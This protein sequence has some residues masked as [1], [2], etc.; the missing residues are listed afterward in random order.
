MDNT[1]K[2]IETA[3][4]LSLER[5]V[6]ELV[7]EGMSIAVSLPTELEQSD[8]SIMSEIVRHK[9]A[10]HLQISGHQRFPFL[11]CG[12]AVQEQKPYLLVNRVSGQLLSRSV[13]PQSGHA[14]DNASRHGFEDS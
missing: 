12:T 10:A 11:N 6:P 3:V 7:V 14:N 8:K 13:G 4:S 1:Y 9:R 5:I 2:I